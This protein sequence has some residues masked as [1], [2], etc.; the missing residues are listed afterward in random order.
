MVAVVVY[1][2]VYICV[3]VADN[4]DVI[5]GGVGILCVVMRLFGIVDCVVA[6]YAGVLW[7]TLLCWL[8]WWRCRYCRLWLYGF[9]VGRLQVRTSY[10]TC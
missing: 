2:V 7:V 3:G 1:V 8:C 5:V 4:V 9:D 10:Q 6:V